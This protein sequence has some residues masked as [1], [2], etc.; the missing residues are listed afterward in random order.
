V[1]D[2]RFANY[3]QQEIIDI[4]ATTVVKYMALEI[5]NSG[6]LEVVVEASFSA[7]RRQFHL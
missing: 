1:I 3:T 2:S 7:G 4:H 6:G 5:R